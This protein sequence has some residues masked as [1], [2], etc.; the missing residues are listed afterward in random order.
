ANPVPSYCTIHTSVDEGER[1]ISVG[2]RPV[3][4][5]GG[6]GAISRTGFILLYRGADVGLE[7]D[8][9]PLRTAYALT[10]AES[11]VCAGLVSGENVHVLS[12]RLGISPQTART[13]LK[14]IYDK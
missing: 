5:G 12:E 6:H 2:I 11:R 1:P 3:Q 4:M 14:R 9:A 10:A 7:V 13:H 8:E